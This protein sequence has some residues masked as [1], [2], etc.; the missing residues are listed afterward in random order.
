MYPFPTNRLLGTDSWT[1]QKDRAQPWSCRLPFT[2]SACN[3]MPCFE[4]MFSSV[5]RFLCHS[6]IPLRPTHLTISYKYTVQIG[7]LNPR[8][9][10]MQLENLRCNATRKLLCTTVDIVCRAPLHCH[11]INITFCYIRG[12]RLLDDRQYALLICTSHCL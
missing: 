2:T 6:S 9:S 10:F 8:P 3:S 11:S 4:N 12:E 7:C 1:V 5:V